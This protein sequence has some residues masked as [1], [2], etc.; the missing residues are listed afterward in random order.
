MSDEIEKVDNDN[1]GGY[2]PV[3]YMCRRPESKAGKLMHFS[4]MYICSDCMQKSMDTMNNMPFDMTEIMSH[5]PTN[6]NFSD[7]LNQS[8]IP[9]KQQVKKKKA[10]E[11][12]KL[13]WHDVPAPHHLKAKLDEYV[14]GQDHAKKV[15]SVGVYN[16]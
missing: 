4:N 3:C 15:I 16:H 2:E 10:E 5:L 14:V 6:L 11:K 9:K 13:E 1:N 12:P 7:L 8:Q